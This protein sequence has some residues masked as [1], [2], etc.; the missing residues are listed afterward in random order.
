M[1]FYNL[2]IS[3]R[4]LIKNKIYTSLIIG[5]FSIGFA[6]FMLIMFFYFTEKKVNKG[7]ANHSE[8]YRLYDSKA[9]SF[10]LNYDLSAVLQENSAE[11]VGVCPMDYFNGMEFIAKDETGKNS[12]LVNDIVCT[13]NSFSEVFSA[14]IVHSESGK[15]FDGLTSFAV[16]RSMA[17]RL[18]GSENAVG[19]T[20]EF[21]NTFIK[22]KGK[23]TSVIEDIPQNSTFKADIL[24][25]GENKDFR[26]STS[27]DKGVCWNP[28]NTFIQLHPG[29]NAINLISNLNKKVNLAQYHIEGL[30]FQRFDDIYL[31]SLPMK[32]MHAKGNA[33][34]LKI[35][36]LIAGLVLFLSAVN[37]VN[38]MVT[39]QYI[40]FR[41]IGISK[42]NGA[43]W[44]QLA[45]FTLTEALLG[46]S[47]ASVISIL[48]LF[49]LLPF[50]FT[51]FGKQLVLDS[52]IILQVSPVMLATLALFIV[53]ISV[54]TLYFQSRF[55]IAEFMAGKRTRKGKQ[56]GKQILLT[57]QLAVSIA[58]IAVVIG[59]SK[60]LFFVKHADLGFNKELLCRID[61]P[62]DANKNA[63]RQEIAKFPFVQ[64]TAFS[65]GCPGK[66]TLRM[67]SNME[68][69]DFTVSCIIMD[70]NFMKTMGIEMLEGRELHQGD[71]NNVCLLNESAARQY[72]F[73]NIEG[74]RFMNGKEG[75][76][77][78]VG[79]IKDFRISSFYNA[80]E[81]VAL[82]Y[83]PDHAS[84]VLSIRLSPGNT[85]AYVD[86]LKQVWKKF[87]PDELMSLTFYD[88]QFQSMYM[89]EEKLVQSIS[90][91]SIV[92]IILTCMGILSQV[93]VSS[94]LR[95]KEIGIRKVNGARTAEV[96]KMLNMDFVKLVFVAFVIACPV[97]WYAIHY[98]LR[99]FASKTTLSWW[100]FAAA[101][102][103]TMGI[104]LLTVSWQSWRAAN[105]NPVEALRYE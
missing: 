8:I 41:S 6:V 14:T 101:G 74:K 78:I 15:L 10:N 19:N 26:F 86:Q 54:F 85:G 75:G 82:I 76:Y 70:D 37:Y 16:S 49:L 105:R 1:P 33:K 65:E 81:P 3:S 62:G 22:F 64:E 23:I 57:V 88:Q 48:L 45:S 21:G 13:T 58:L 43:S 32:D 17:T 104:T 99:N 25:N 103:V 72:G 5:G 61:M 100:V 97:S 56:A 59:I 95:T 60:Q 24:L 91:F 28:T 71:R 63:F 53:L 40:K 7:F 12:V 2:K 96:L 80:I 93:I 51:L 30:G 87:L 67:G 47:I 52:E 68:D 94:L 84:G 9:N 27:C 11:I 18:F 90:F 36:L 20:L 83:D 89:K 92:A 39:Q 29:A 38:Y 50:S 79:I 31:S 35:F 102:L 55:N 42:T 77:E 98:W 73:D 46:I 34:L 66:I 44:R 69:N 4:Y